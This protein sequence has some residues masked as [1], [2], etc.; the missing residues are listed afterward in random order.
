MDWDYLKAPSPKESMHSILLAH[1]E[2]YEIQEADRRS[3]PHF[4]IAVW[5]KLQNTAQL[6]A[7]LLL[8]YTDKESHFWSI[9]DTAR[10]HAMKCTILLSGAVDLKVK[11][12]KSLD[13]YLCH[14][15][16]HI[17]C[18]IEELRFN[19]KLIEMHTQNK[20]NLG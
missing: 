6:P 12:I 4:E 13:I 19:G 17:K 14:P 7:M 3:E 5:L 20:Y 18:E 1:L 2:R 9:V 8:E 10:M 16:P 15:N 11:K